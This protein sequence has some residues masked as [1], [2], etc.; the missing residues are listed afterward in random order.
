MRD[1]AVSV[2]PVSVAIALLF[3]GIVGEVFGLHP[4]R[5]AAG[6]KPIETLRYEKSEAYLIYP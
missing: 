4:A 6:L 3:A 2:T 5:K 1:A